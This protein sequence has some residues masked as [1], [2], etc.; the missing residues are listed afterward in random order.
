MNKL[1]YFSACSFS[2]AIILLLDE[3]KIN[4]ERNEI[5]QYDL[6]ISKYHKINSFYPIFEDKYCNNE[7]DASISVSGFE[8]RA[9]VN[10]NNNV[11]I[12][13]ISSFLAINEYIFEKYGFDYK[14]L[15][16]NDIVERIKINEMIWWLTHEL[17]E[18][19]LSILV[20]EKHLK[21]FE[22]NLLDNSPNSFIVRKA[23][24]KLREILLSVQDKIRENEFCAIQNV[25]YADFFLLA[26]ISILDYMNMIN[27]NFDLCILKK[28]YL[29]MKSR[30]NF[31]NILKLRIS[32]F[33]PNKNYFS[34]DD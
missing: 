6:L 14:Y 19:S 12:I 8:S 30:P 9:I 11:K 34:I 27:W 2:R 24:L 13:K 15:Y 16:G 33:K 7:I 3:L 5:L 23:E 20:Y 28:W 32:G 1:T 29:I 17:Y 31:R 18:N 4:Y 26:Q 10:E 25:T 21:S 22:K